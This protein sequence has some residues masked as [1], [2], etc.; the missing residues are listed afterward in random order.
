MLKKIFLLLILICKPISASYMASMDDS[1]DEESRHLIPSAAGRE[2]DEGYNSMVISSAIAGQFSI[3]EKDSDKLENC[4]QQRAFTFDEPLNQKIGR[5]I[6]GFMGFAAAQGWDPL[7]IFTLLNSVLLMTGY[8]V[9]VGSN[10][11]WVIIGAITG[12]LTPATSTHLGEG[13]AEVASHSYLLK[14][15][16]VVNR[17]PIIRRIES[18]LEIPESYRLEGKSTYFK[19]LNAIYAGAWSVIYASVLS[20]L[21]HKK[22]NRLLF[23]IFVGPYALSKFSQLYKYTSAAAKKHIR[24]EKHRGEIE[25]TKIKRG[26]IR[27]HLE[28]LKLHERGDNEIDETYKSISSKEV[29][30]PEKIGA[31][32]R[33][34]KA[35]LIPIQDISKGQ[36]DFDMHESLSNSKEKNNYTEL[37][38]NRH[39]SQS[40]K[41]KTVT[42]L[43]NVISCGAII[44]RY[45]LYSWLIDYSFGAWGITEG[46]ARNI[47]TYGGAAILDIV[48]TFFE[49]GGIQEYFNSIFKNDF[50]YWYAENHP[51]IR[52]TIGISSLILGGVLA[53]PDSWYAWTKLTALPRGDLKTENHIDNDIRIPI[54]LFMVFDGWPRNGAFLASG[55]DEFISNARHRGRQL[56]SCLSCRRIKA[57]GRGD[58]I[59]RISRAAKKLQ[60]VVDDLNPDGVDQIYDWLFKGPSV[61]GVQ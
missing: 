5:W 8:K 13:F 16:P 49:E 22:E 2:A 50:P 47:L 52:R 7:I 21:E 59:D 25:I 1:S 18:P 55:Y 34:G 33:N 30:I 15:M 54:L 53:I 29:S 43:T 31:L 48:A 10:L 61:N 44:S 11:D 4:I 28:T 20:G 12:L 14:R 36:V 46:L 39:M 38:V 26:T 27:Q 40:L 51:K 3:E 32:N 60:E 19:L 57:I 56:F 6:G 41:D 45:F 42:R 35:R 17:L 23:W 24:W 37:D 9:P 58:K